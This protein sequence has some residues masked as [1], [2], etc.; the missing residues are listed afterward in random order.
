MTSLNGDYAESVAPLLA[1]ARNPLSLLLHEVFSAQPCIPIFK[2]KREERQSCNAKQCKDIWN[3]K[4][5]T[6][7][8]VYDVLSNY[9]I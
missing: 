8:Y 9:E 4:K 3:G 5:R 1:E 6:K 2:P 7:K